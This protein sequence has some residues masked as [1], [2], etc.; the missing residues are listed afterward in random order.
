MVLMEIGYGRCRKLTQRPISVGANIPRV[1]ARKSNPQCVEEENASD[2]VETVRNRQACEN[3][4][5]RLEMSHC[6]SP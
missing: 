6:K 5:K 4:R 3:E 1:G 2:G